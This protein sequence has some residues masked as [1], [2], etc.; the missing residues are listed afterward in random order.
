VF[1]A[2]SRHVEVDVHVVREKVLEIRYIPIKDE[3][4]DMFTKTLSIPK[5]KAM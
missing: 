1:H 5:F 3:V 2:R 4:V